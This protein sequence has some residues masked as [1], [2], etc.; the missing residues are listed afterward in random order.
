MISILSRIFIKDCENYKNSQVRR[1]YGILCSVVGIILNILLFIGKYLIGIISSSVA[2][3][4]DAFNNLTDAASSI[5]TLV[6]FKMS[7]KL[8]DKKHPFGHGRIEYVA[9]FVVSIFII[10]TAYELGQSSLERLLNPLNPVVSTITIII[11]IISVII[12]IYMYLYNKGIGK[13]TGS[14]AMR[15]VAVDSISDAV[16]TFAVI[17]S[18]IIYSVWGINLDAICGLL[19]AIFILRAGIL[20]AKDTLDPV[21][22]SAPDPQLVREIKDIIFDHDAIIGTHD[23]IVHDYGGGNVMVTVHAEVRANSNLVEIHEQIDHIEK[24]VLERLGCEMLVHIDPIV[25]ECEDTMILQEKVLKLISEINSDMT[26]HDFRTVKDGDITQLIF[27]VS[28]PVSKK[29]TRKN[30]KEIIENKINSEMENCIALVHIDH[31]FD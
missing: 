28:I 18:I 5:I 11:L 27:E 15:A 12:K 17:L 31:H 30:A 1:S 25:T 6:G 10:L 14:E 29:L 21:L 24:E 9:G 22:G 13:K 2:I 20:T 26:M 8:P 19:V 23:M 4:A 3:T 16:A 7:G